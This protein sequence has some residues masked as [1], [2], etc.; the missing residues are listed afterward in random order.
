[1][2]KKSKKFGTLQIKNGQEFIRFDLIPYKSFES[3]HKEYFR[4]ILEIAKNQKVLLIGFS[5]D[6][7]NY[8]MDIRTLFSN[9]NELELL[10]PLIFNSLNMDCIAIDGPIP[11]IDGTVHYDEIYGKRNKYFANSLA[12]EHFLLNNDSDYIKDIRTRKIIRDFLFD[13]HSIYI[14]SKMITVVNQIKENFDYIPI[15]PYLK[16]FNGGSDFFKVTGYILDCILKT[17]D[18]Q[19]V[20]LSFVNYYRQIDIYHNYGLGE[21]ESGQT[22]AYDIETGESFIEK[23]S[24]DEIQMEWMKQEKIWNE[25]FIS[26]LKLLSE[27]FNK[28]IYL[29]ISVN[30]EISSQD[31]HVIPA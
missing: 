20:F 5:L 6:T 27:T 3:V 22:G 11:D 13:F 16:L 31:F 26:N 2:K 14:E 12:L 15:E 7:E 10:I 30:S 1:M 24:S 9:F 17:P 4:K 19:V 21:F 18:C 29:R 25:R 23:P 8:N 28:D